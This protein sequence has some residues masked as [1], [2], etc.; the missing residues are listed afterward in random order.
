MI[1]P[2]CKQKVENGYNQG[3][4]MKYKAIFFDLDGTLVDTLDDLTDAMNYALSQLGQPAVCRD[5]CREMIGKGLA[6]FAD[7][8]L[9]EG[10]K[11]L[12]QTLVDAMKARY[13]RTCLDKTRVYDGVAELVSQCRQKGLRLGVVSNKSHPLTVKITEHYFGCNV[14]GVILGQKED[15]RIKPDPEPIRIAMKA[16]GIDSPRETLYVG[17]S[18]VD[19]ETARNAGTDFVAVGWGFRSEQQLRQAGAETIIHDAGDLWNLILG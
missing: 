19:A 14:F 16:V 8:A 2:F 13:V 15:V 18:D 4:T 10:A 12:Q 7:K 1:P 6:A 11:H 17:D 3:R 9:P 5:A